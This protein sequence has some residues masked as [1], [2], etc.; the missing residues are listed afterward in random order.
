MAIKG[1]GANAAPTREY[2]DVFPSY[3]ALAEESM[4][5]E[6]IQPAHRQVVRRYFEAIRPGN[7]LNDARRTSEG[8]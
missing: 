8:E 6:T 4:Q 1:F 3:A 2:Q 5:D 7:A